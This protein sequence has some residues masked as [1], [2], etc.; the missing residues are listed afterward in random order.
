MQSLLAEPDRFAR[1]AAIDSTG[2]AAGLAEAPSRRDDINGADA[3]RSGTLN[4]SA[5]NQRR[6]AGAWH[7]PLSRPLTTRNAA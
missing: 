4:A 1:L 5:S 7:A 3:A 6:G 2:A